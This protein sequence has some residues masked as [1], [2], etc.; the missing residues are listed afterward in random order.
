MESRPAHVAQ[1]ESGPALP[2]RWGY[3]ASRDAVGRSLWCRHVCG[4]CRGL[5]APGLRRQPRTNPR[6][7]QPQQYSVGAHCN[8][9]SGFR[10]SPCRR[11]NDPIHCDGDNVR[12]HDAVGNECRELVLVEQRRRERQRD[13]SRD[14]R[15]RRRRRHRGGIPD[16]QWQG[17]RDYR[18]A[19]ARHVHDQRN[20]QGRI[21]RRDPAEGA[22]SGR[23]QYRHDAFRDDRRVRR[24]R[25]IR[26]LTRSGDVERQHHQLRAV[27]ADDDCVGRHA[28]RSCPDASGAD[29][30]VPDGQRHGASRRRDVAVHRDREDVR[31][32]IAGGDQPRD[33]DDVER[34]GGDRQQRGSGGGHRTGRR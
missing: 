19:G 14:R 34:V 33:M 24:V 20:A 6:P 1:R 9:G 28:H 2:G 29:G 23:R 30:G 16:H 8:L 21:V 15:R 7:F 13:R 18:A 31:R 3:H 10:I 5:A 22:R 4:T 12:R 25:N 26:R 32:I 27:L 17:P 11:S